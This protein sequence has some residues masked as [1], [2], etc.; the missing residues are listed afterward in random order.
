MPRKSKKQTGM[1]DPS[2]NNQGRSEWMKTY[3]KNIRM[4]KD[5]Q[6]D[7]TEDVKPIFISNFFRI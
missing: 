1:I 2:T 5:K 7:V 3:N 4:Q 6:K